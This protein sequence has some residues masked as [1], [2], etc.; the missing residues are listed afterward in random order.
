MS[1]VKEFVTKEKGENNIGMD[2]FE[3]YIPFSTYVKNGCTALYLAVRLGNVDIVKE[4]AH[5]MTQEGLELKSFSGSSALHQAV[6]YE[7]IDIVQ[8]LV[9]L[10]RKEGLEIKDDDGDTPLNYA[11]LKGN[12]YIVKALVQ[13]MRQEGLE[14]RNSKAEIALPR[15]I[16]KGHMPFCPSSSLEEM[17][18]RLARS[19]YSLTPLELIDQPNG[20]AFICYCLDTSTQI[21]LAW[22]LLHRYPNFAMAVYRRESPMLKSSLLYLYV[23]ASKYVHSTSPKRGSA[24]SLTFSGNNDG[25][26]TRREED[27]SL[28]NNLILQRS[29]NLSQ[30]K[31]SIENS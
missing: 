7:R 17:A 26:S 13:S 8:V 15:A 19:I 16:S 10:M 3:R 24:T 4:L 14:I 1:L 21:D 31:F 23:I 18:W 28:K 20:G 30:P 22:D 27:Y 25:G 9:P 12:A 11:V 29:N 6:G 5:M 2:D